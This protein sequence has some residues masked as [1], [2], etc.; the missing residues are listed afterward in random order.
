MEITKKEFKF[1]KLLLSSVAK[2][3][4]ALRKGGALSRRGAERY[5]MLTEIIRKLE[6]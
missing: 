2:K 3:Y 5:E 6:N 1:L 4:E